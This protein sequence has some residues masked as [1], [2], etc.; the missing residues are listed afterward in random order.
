MPQGGTP[1]V[2]LAWRRPFT[3]AVLVQPAMTVVPALEQPS[4]SICMACLAMSKHDV[5][6]WGWIVDH[7]GIN[8]HI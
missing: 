8:E 7:E 4:S 3:V 6:L 1:L 2:P 5:V